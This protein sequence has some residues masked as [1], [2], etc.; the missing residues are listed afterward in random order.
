MTT[1]HKN[2]ISRWESR[3]K[4][5]ARD[6]VGAALILALVFLVAVSGMVLAL[7]GSTSNN[8]LN[9]VHFTATRTVDNA[10]S[11]AIE[12]AVQS[13]RYTPTLE[14]GGIAQT[15]NASPPIVLL[16]VRPDFQLRRCQQFDGYRRLV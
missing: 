13:I 11:N 9:S 3:R 12:V 1:N 16:G 6:E 8:L 4:D 5:A 2:T 10:A 15:L 7:A 14:T